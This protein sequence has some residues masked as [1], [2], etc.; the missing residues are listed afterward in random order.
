MEN[1]RGITVSSSI[2]TIAEEIINR[3]LLKTV[4]FTQAQAGGKK[5]AS[6]TDH[7]FILRNIME[8]A[9]K[10]GRHLLVSFFDVKKAYD[11]ADMKNMLYILHKN[12][13]TGKIWR[14][15]RSL[16]VGLT[17]KVKTKAG[18]TREIKRETGG[19][20]GGKLM[21]P[22]FA[23]SMDTI[24]EEME[25]QGDLGIETM[26]QTIPALLFMDDLT[27]MA[28][29]YVQEQKTLDA[30]HNFGIKHKIEWGQDK[31]KVMEVG[32]QKEN[33]TRWKLGDKEIENCRTYK[34]LGEIISRDGTN[35][36]NLKGRRDKVTSRQ[37]AS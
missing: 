34:Y 35:D 23:K 37:K 25:E 5:G 29:G 1:Q 21:V 16:N 27:T 4:K 19:K 7:V 17:A 22:L 32:R 15:T 14:L 20:Q 10:E 36:E 3:R 8:L 28:E 2:G 6:P 30:V 31:C 33:K 24:A 18:L 12:G 9:K 26:G 11:R 13:F